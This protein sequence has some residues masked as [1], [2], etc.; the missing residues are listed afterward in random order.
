MKNE[1]RKH[2]ENAKNKNEISC[3]KN[4]ISVKIKM[5]FH[6]TLKWNFMLRSKEFHAAI[7]VKFQNTIWCEKRDVFPFFKKVSVLI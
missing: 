3:N 5:K 4:E 6:V 2:D 1:T 7:K